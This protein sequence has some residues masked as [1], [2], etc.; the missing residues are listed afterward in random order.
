MGAYNL[1][2]SILGA[3][4]Q[5]WVS[6]SLVDKREK[7]T[8]LQRHD[9]CCDKDKHRMQRVPEGGSADLEPNLD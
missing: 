5:M 8:N 7:E 1:P 9:K 6:H 4:T 3:G 2:T